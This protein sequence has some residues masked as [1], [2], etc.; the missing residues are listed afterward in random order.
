MVEG[1]LEPEDIKL[2]FSPQLARIIREPVWHPSQVLE[3]Q[4]D[5]SL[6]MKL[7]VAN[8]VDLYR[9]VLRWGDQ[10]EV[11][12]PKELRQALDQTARDMLNIYG[13]SKHS[14]R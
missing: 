14:V 11:L 7:R 2:K 12:E 13:S 6:I 9:L 5:G 4:D 8:T 3:P 10:V 1:D